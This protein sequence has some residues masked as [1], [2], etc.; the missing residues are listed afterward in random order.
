MALTFGCALLMLA[1]GVPGLRRSGSRRGSR[2][3]ALIP[4]QPL[5]SGP[6]GFPEQYD[7]AVSRDSGPSSFKLVVKF[8]DETKFRAYGALPEA[9]DTACL[10]DVA[11]VVSAFG[12][13]FTPI[14]AEIDPQLDDLAHRAE[15]ASGMA[16][17]DFRSIVDVR[18][19]VEDGEHLV[20]AAK[21]FDNLG[22]IEYVSIQ[23]VSPVEPQAVPEALTTCHS[24]APGDGS[25]PSF[26]ERQGYRGAD[27]FDA[28]H[29]QDRLHVYGEGIRYTDCEIG[30]HT[31]HSEFVGKHITDLHPL[32]QARDHG[33]ASLSVTL[34]QPG[35]GVKGLA[36]KADA[37]FSTEDGI[38]GGRPQAIKNA[39]AAS[40][41][42]DVVLLEMQTSFPYGGP[43]ELDQTVWSVV[44]TGVDAGIV[45]VAAGGNGNRNLDGSDHSDYMARGDSGAIIVGA[46]DENHRK[47]H[48]STHGRRV[49]VQAWGGQVMSA[50]YARCTGFEGSDDPNRA[51]TPS[52]GG[53]SSASAV[54]AGAVTLFQ[55][56]AL[57]ELGAPLPPKELR[58]LLKATGHPQQGGDAHVGPHPNLRAAVERAGS[59]GRASDFV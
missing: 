32:R 49:D 23:E 18:L 53:T 5:E 9:H 12:A 8:A 56:W 19:P 14:F 29:L 55:S 35:F 27:Q 57:R 34:G 44:K 2:K 31:N 39:V 45:V 26:V 21:H 51:Y 38:H 3:T 6:I 17:P 20:S 40:K 59:S 10:A 28:D 58:Q 13:T 11:E 36:Y 42:G 30:Y 25:I 54:M 4:R 33:T 47:K 52:Y 15:E 50:G 48:F 16:Q 37:A 43:A 22:C 7:A 41:A 1:S 24:T 46:G